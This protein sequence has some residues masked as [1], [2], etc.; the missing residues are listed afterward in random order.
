MYYIHYPLFTS[1]QIHEHMKTCIINS[2]HDFYCPHLKIE[3][4]LLN[5]KKPNPKDL[6]CNELEYQKS[7]SNECTQFLSCPNLLPHPSREEG[8]LINCRDPNKFEDLIWGNL[9]MG[10]WPLV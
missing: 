5:L 2:L 9:G 1:N 8:I 7:P 6:W 4:K 3:I 10:C